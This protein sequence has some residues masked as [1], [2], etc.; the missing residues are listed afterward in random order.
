MSKQ[1]GVKPVDEKRKVFNETEEKIRNIKLSVAEDDKEI[2]AMEGKIIKLGQAGRRQQAL[3]EA[4]DLRTLR[5]LRDGKN[6]RMR[7]LQKNLNGLREAL[8][9]IDMQQS[10]KKISDQKSQ[11]LSQVDVVGMQSIGYESRAV[12]IGLEQLLTS[13]GVNE[14]AAEKDLMENERLFE[15]LMRGASTGVVKEERELAPPITKTTRTQSA[16]KKVNPKF[17]RLDELIYF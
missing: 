2:E 17:S 1:L 16:P 7:V 13:A 6:N 10:V 11:L 14:E 3:S 15:E 4:E 9:T 12:D 8:G 5:A